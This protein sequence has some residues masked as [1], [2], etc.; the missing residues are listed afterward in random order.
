MGFFDLFHMFTGKNGFHVEEDIHS[1]F[2]CGDA[3]WTRQRC[4][5]SGQSLIAV[6][7]GRGSC[8]VCRRKRLKATNSGTS[9]T[10]KS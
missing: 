4:G 3:H 9:F 8:P 2:Q 7:R 6:S 1:G 5:G 10:H